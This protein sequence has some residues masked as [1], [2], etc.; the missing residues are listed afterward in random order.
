MYDNSIDID[1]VD[2]VDLLNI[3]L[4]P[5]FVEKWRHRY[6]EKFIKLFQFKVLDAL[7]SRKPIKIDNLY[8][9]LTK[10]CKY[11]QDTVED[12]FNNIEIEIYSP[13]ICGRLTKNSSYR[14]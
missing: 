10:K 8:I 4:S 1:L 3:T 11:S 12:F 2:F 9:Y 13:L 7:S 14:S 5:S 6:S